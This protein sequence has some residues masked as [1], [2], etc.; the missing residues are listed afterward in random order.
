MRLFFVFIIL[1]SGVLAILVVS[2]ASYEEG[3][4]FF[5]DYIEIGLNAPNVNVGEIV[6]LELELFGRGNESVIVSPRIEIYNDEVNIETIDIDSIEVF[7]NDKI[8]INISLDTEKYSAGNYLAIAVAEYNNS[9]VAVENPFR[10][11]EFS[12]NVVEYTK[13]FRENKVERFEILAESLWDSDMKDVYIE[14]NILNFDSASFVSSSEDLLAWRKQLFVGFL[15]MSEIDASSF[16]AELVL[17]YENESVSEIVELEMIR[18][19]DYIFYVVILIFVLTFC[20]LV[21]RSVVF[22]RRFGKHKIK[23]R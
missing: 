3:I 14:V 21:W 16:D 7:S 19:F 13:Y 1:C 15:D 22:V 2:S 17:Y 18:G 11:G 12:I 8:I 6:P 20:F 4:S 23:K 10:L 5:D 9:I